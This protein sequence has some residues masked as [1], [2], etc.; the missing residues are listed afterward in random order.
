MYKEY[1]GLL[2][3]PFRMTP[4]TRYLF[5]SSKH[6]EAISSLMYGI[7]EKKGF[8]AI[9]GEIGTGKTTLCRAI[10]NQIDEQT[11]TAI[12]LNPAMTQLELLHSILDD[13]GIEEDLESP[14]TKMLLDR[15]NI[16]LIEQAQAGGNVAVIIDEA[17]NLDT[18]VLEFIRMLSNLETE[19][20]KLLQIIL[21]GQPELNEMLKLPRLEQLRQRIAVRYHITPL[22]NK[23]V[24][25]YIRHRLMI[26]GDEDC[27][28]FTQQAIDAICEYSGGTP[29]LINIICDK[30][31][32]AA[33][34][35][36]RKEIDGEIASTAIRDHEGP[37]IHAAAQKAARARNISQ[38]ANSPIPIQTTRSVVAASGPS[39]MPGPDYK[40][41]IALGI[42]AALIAAVLSL[43]SSNQVAQSSTSPQ[44]GQ[45]TNI[46]GTAALVSGAAPTR[47]SRT[48]TS[49][50]PSIL[51]AWSLDENLTSE[52]AAGLT[53]IEFN[54]S[55]STIA[56][57][58]LPALIKSDGA[59]IALVQASATSYTFYD[60]SRI[61][62][63]HPINGPNAAYVQVPRILYDNLGPVS[64]RILIPMKFAY[65]KG[66]PTKDQILE[67]VDRALPNVLPGQR[68]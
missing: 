57:I 58:D 14:T 40:P 15:L 25:L 41:Y 16:F 9:T 21:V 49:S 35:C 24:P 13:L 6:E 55:L 1:F 56:K 23:E 59:E 22:D 51:R 5:R 33:Y 68:L 26:A 27:V 60:P 20:E 62:L 43:S 4:D 12:I 7:S 17:Q 46:S 44:S 42:L 36:G 18:D 66:N 47:R 11:K 8:I 53:S 38:Q 10:L 37:D 3:E 34:A 54:A 2:D 65:P 31:M 30:C 28:T 39:T 63:R 45:S 61:D 50:L 52:R 29:R 64:V 67:L 48:S 32:L 19:Q